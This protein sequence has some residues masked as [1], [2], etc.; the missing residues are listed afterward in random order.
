MYTCG[1]AAH[2]EREREREATERSIAEREHGVASQKALHRVVEC[3][4]LA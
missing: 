4:Y 1:Q 2:T 3:A